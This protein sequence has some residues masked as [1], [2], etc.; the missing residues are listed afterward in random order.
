MKGAEKYSIGLWLLT[1]VLVT[2]FALQYSQ[3][4]DNDG[5]VIFAGESA[6][7]Y[8]VVGNCPDG[9]EIFGWGNRAVGTNGSELGCFNADGE[10]LDSITNLAS[11]RDVVCGR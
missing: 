6:A 11:C 2:T 7:D 1:L 5:S 10:R 3:H 4:L 9:V 8:F